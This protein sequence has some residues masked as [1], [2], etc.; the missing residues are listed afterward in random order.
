VCKL[1]WCTVCLHSDLSMMSSDGSRRMDTGG[2]GVVGEVKCICAHYSFISD[3]SVLTPASAK[4]T[5][6]VIPLLLPLVLD[7]FTQ[8]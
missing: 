5:I 7:I 3:S 4:K 1:K 8:C 6:S 2:G